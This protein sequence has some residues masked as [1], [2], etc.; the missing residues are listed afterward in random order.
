M[1]TCPICNKQILK[2]KEHILSVHEKSTCQFQCDKC[3]RCLP[4]QAELKGHK[5]RVHERVKCEKCDQVGRVKEWWII[6][7][8]V[9]YDCL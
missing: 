9:N 2:V 5:K 4:T 3:P 8:I 7:E 1:K 6:K